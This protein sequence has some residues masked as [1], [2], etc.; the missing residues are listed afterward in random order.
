VIKAFFVI[1]GGNAFGV[2]VERVMLDWFG[3]FGS[4][5]V[6][7]GRPALTLGGLAA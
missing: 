6:V 7:I 1:V 5:G 4:D 3:L 2:V